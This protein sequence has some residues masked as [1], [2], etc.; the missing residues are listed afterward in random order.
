MPNQIRAVFVASK[1]ALNA[2]LFCL[3]TSLSAHASDV[4][5]IDVRP[6]L[7]GRAVTTLTDGKL[8]PWTKGIDGRGRA[9]GYLTL[10]A[11]VANGDTNVN[12]LPGDG[13]FKADSAHPFVQLNFSNAD[14]KSPQTR[15]VEGA[16]EFTFPVPTNQYKSM[17]VFMTSSE[18]PS[19]LHFELTYAD[20]TLDQRDILLPDYYN[21]A[22]VGDRSLFSLAKDLPKWDATGRM[23]EKNHH[24]IHGVD[25]HPDAAKKLVSVHVAK[26]ASGYLVFW[27]ATGVTAN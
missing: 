11:A 15:G 5:Q 10:E 16:G 7:T 3:L 4:I 27:G 24:Y 21:D 20:G 18:G 19:H 23:R 22:P 17:L 9:D 12:A 13:A 1:Q 2:I 8:V 26:T 14:G 6:I 25:L